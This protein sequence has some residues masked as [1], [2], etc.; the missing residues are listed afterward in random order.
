MLPNIPLV[1]QRTKQ[2]IIL[3]PPN[4]SEFSYSSLLYVHDDSASFTTTTRSFAVVN[5]S[6][7]GLKFH[8]RSYRIIIISIRSI[9]SHHHFLSQ[10]P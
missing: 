4:Q 1:K 7:L 10:Y 5:N 9:I 2:K 6:Y 3:L 8:P